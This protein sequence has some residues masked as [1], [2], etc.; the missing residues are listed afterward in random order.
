MKDSS[1]LALSLSAVLFALF[2]VSVAIG[3]A[4]RGALL[5]PV[6]EALLLFVSVLCFAV[7]VLKREADA[8]IDQNK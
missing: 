8:R 3:A 7:G 5:G 1:A 4:Q 2:F 6:A